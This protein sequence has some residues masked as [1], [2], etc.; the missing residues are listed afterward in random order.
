[1]ADQDRKPD[2]EPKEPR[3][4]EPKKPDADRP[5]DPE[6]DQTVHGDDEL[7]V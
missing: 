3:P 6:K 7:V 2:Q 1:M 5:H 4:S